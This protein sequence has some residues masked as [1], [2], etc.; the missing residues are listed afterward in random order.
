MGTSTSQYVQAMPI[1]TDEAKLEL[2]AVELELFA[3][4]TATQQLS[5]R[6]REFD[7]MH[8]R[9]ESALVQQRQELEP[10]PQQQQEQPSR[11]SLPKLEAEAVR[12][13]ASII[14]GYIMATRRVSRVPSIASILST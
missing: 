12:T 1:T 9:Y 13:S 10:E 8:R 5:E 14:Y 7:E 4:S 11:S 6:E 3:T 2:D